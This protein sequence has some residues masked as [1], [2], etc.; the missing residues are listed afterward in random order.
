MK[1]MVLTILAVLI[2]IFSSLFVY[3]ITIERP[4]QTNSTDENFIDTQEIV[5]EIDNLTIHE[6]DE[7][8]IGKMI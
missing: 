4:E 8:D 7:I 2:L 6:D 3:Y 1:K 5:T